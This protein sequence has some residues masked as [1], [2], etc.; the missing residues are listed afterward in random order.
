[1]PKGVLSKSL[2]LLAGTMLMIAVSLVPVMAQY[3]TGSLGGTVVD[4]SGASVPDAKVQ[5]QNA[6]TGFTQTADTS[7]DGSFLFPRLPV[8][9]YKLTVEKTGFTRYVQEGTTLTLNQAATIPVE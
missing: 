2:V 4:Q 3:T 8:G 9:N 7:S 1:M 6:D 5:I